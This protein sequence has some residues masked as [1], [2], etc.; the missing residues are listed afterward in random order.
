MSILNKELRARLTGLYCLHLGST[1]TLQ[2]KVEKESLDRA[3]TTL[4]INHYINNIH[5][6]IMNK[7]RSIL[8][9]GALISFVTNNK[10]MTMQPYQES[11]L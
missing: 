7:L 6:V 3:T 11:L 5:G 10:V 8:T 1:P 4:I 2:I 9:I